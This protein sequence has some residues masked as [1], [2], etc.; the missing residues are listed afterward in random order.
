[1]KRG[2]SLATLQA[3]IQTGPNNLPRFAGIGVLF[4]VFQ[5]PIELCLL[6]IGKGDVGRFLDA[7]PKILSQLDPLGDGQ[8]AEVEFRVPHVASVSLK[9]LSP[10]ALSMY[11]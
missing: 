11:R 7:V 4:K 9:G 1:M 2:G 5:A 10:Q 8:L 3:P 6:S